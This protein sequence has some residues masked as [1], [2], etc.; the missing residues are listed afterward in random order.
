MSG[1]SK[2]ST[3]KRQKGATDAKRGQLFTKLAR[4]IT[5]AARTGLPDPE[6]N[7]RL[8]L[9]IQRARAENMPKD[10]I[11]RAIERAT[12]AGGGDNFDEVTYEAFLPGGI[13][14]I[15][16]AQTDNRNRTVGEVRA[17]VTRG[18]GNVGADG[19]VTW[20]FDNV[21][22]IVVKSGGMDADELALLA[23]DA[24]ATEFESDEESTVIFTDPTDLHKVQ[25]TLSASGLEIESSELV[26]K[27]KD[28]ITVEP[29]QAVKVIR[30]IEKL[31]DLDDVSNVYTNLN[32]T[33][34]VFAQVGA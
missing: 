6:A 30:L 12:A 29:D 16:Q 24:G 27:A 3:I 23:I 11:E 33:D 25:E 14:L 17:A 2:W 7:G 19:S 34:E 10:N 15:I 8:R 21:G 20:M 4:E 13:A 9:A 5:V 28:L 22:Q 32:V 1:H 18:G 31:E 26:M